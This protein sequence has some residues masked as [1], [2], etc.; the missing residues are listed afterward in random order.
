LKRI[1]FDVEADGFLDELTQ[2]HCLVLR[3]LD[4]DTVVSC[5][6]SASGYTPIS[7][8]LSLLSEA[9]RI[10]AHNGIKYDLPALQKVYPQWKPK[11]RLLDTYTTACMRWAHQREL[12]FQL[13]RK[14]RLPGRYA[15]SH[16]LVA[17]G[18][19]LG[20]LKAEYTGGFEKWNPVMQTYCEADTATTK[21]LVKRI[22]EATVSQPA[23]ETEHELAYYL[24]AQENNGWPFDV[25]KAQALQAELAARRQDVTMELIAAFPS[26]LARDGKHPFTPKKDNKKKGAVAGA[27]YS[28]L[29]LVE[30]NPGSRGHL[31]NRLK[32]L[33]GW[34]PTEF[35]ESGDPKMDEDALRGLPYPHIDKVIEYLVLQKRLGQLAEG[36]QALMGHATKDRPH[37]GRLTGLHHIHG[38]VKQN[39]AI[40]H[41]AAHSSPNIAQVPR[42]GSKWG[43]EFRE[44]FMVPDGWVQIGADASGLELRCLAHETTKYDDGAYAKV[45]LE[46][47]P[48][49]LTRDALGLPQDKP[50]RSDAKTWK[51]AWLYGGGDY[52][53]GTIIMKYFY[54]KGASD[55]QIKNLGADSRKKYLNYVP[56][57]KYVIDDLQSQAKK[58]GYIRLVDDRRAYIRHRHAVLNTRLQGN[59][60]II[61]K[62]WI[63]DF[64][65]KLVEG[66][67]PQGWRD[68][69]AGLGW[70]H[71]EVQ[72]AVRTNMAQVVCSTLVGS[73]R[74]MT[75]HFNFR[76]QLDGEAKIGRNWKDTH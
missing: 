49:S 47:D 56:A 69:W 63:V 61:C 33:Y 50:A 76:C 22:I 74:S 9:E 58:F 51:Y 31:A 11:G 75:G 72:L 8:G 62:R 44:L 52:K 17:W 6:D 28:K 57:L 2:I 42:V 29:K 73:I 18:Y 48:H 43:A 41:R 40:T 53:L 23:L 5:T 13:V 59:G 65:R 45:L 55:N 32:T 16:E 10:Y 26:W 54:P 19:R 39:H 35:T 27:P 38:R 25:E 34:T 3:D 64:N 71:D 60:A 68:N 12:D 14:G 67:G 36:K 46:G 1:V 66:L 21:A 37:G 30:F 20:I 4:S 15:G 7:E 70:I 24:A